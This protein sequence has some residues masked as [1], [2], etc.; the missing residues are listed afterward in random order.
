MKEKASY[1]IKFCGAFMVD[2]NLEE[3]EYAGIG[4]FK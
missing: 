1:K 2:F 3:T 4:E